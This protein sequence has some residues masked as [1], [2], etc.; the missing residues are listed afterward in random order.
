MSRVVVKDR[1]TKLYQFPLVSPITSLHIGLKSVQLLATASQDNVIRLWRLLNEREP[2]LE[3]DV[4]KGWEGYARAL[5]G[6]RAGGIH[7]GAGS[8]SSGGA[9]TSSIPGSSSSAP[10]S[11]FSII[12][13]SFD[14]SEELLLCGLDSGHILLFDL[15][16]KKLLRVF[17]TVGGLTSS[18]VT[19]TSSS[20]SSSLNPHSITCL[21][22]HPFGDYFASG[23]QDH[24]VKVWDM[25][26]KN[27]LQTYKGHVKGISALR[28]TPDG[29][30][31]VSGDSQG[32][33]KLWDLTAGKILTQF[34]SHKGAITCLDFHPTEFL[35][36]T[37]SEDGSVRYWDLDRFQLASGTQRDET[38]PLQ[39][40]SFTPDGRFLL[41][42]SQ[43]HLRV[44]SWEPDTLH[45]TVKI[46]WEGISDFAIHQGFKNGFGVAK[47][48]NELAAWC[49]ILEKLA[50]Y[51]E[52]YVSP[53][54]Q[55]KRSDSPPRKRGEERKSSGQ[56]KTSSSSRSSGGG[57]RQARAA[58]KTPVSDV[59]SSSQHDTESSS[60]SD[61]NLVPKN[62]TQDTQ[63][64]LNQLRSSQFNMRSEL[65]R[66]RRRQELE[67]KFR[68][69]RMGL[70]NG[71]DDESR[72]DKS[73]D[74]TDTKVKSSADSSLS[75]S[76]SV[77]TPPP[78]G[79]SGPGNTTSH[80]QTVSPTESQ[81]PVRHN[82]QSKE[83]ASSSQKKDDAPPPLQRKPFSQR[84]PQ[85]LHTDDN[86]NVNYVVNSSSDATPPKSRERS[87]SDPNIVV[88]LAADNNAH[89]SNRDDVYHHHKKAQ[90]SKPRR[91]AAEHGNR[92]TSLNDLE[93]QITEESKLMRHIISGRLASMN[94]VARLWHENFKLEAINHLC[95]L[96]DPAVTVDV[97]A[98]LNQEPHA[99]YFTLQMC[100]KLLTLQVPLMDSKYEPYLK[101][102]MNTTEQL[103]KRFYGMVKQSL[104]APRL[105]RN[106]A[107]PP[108][109]SRFHR[110]AKC[111]QL[112]LTLRG[113]L[114]RLRTRHDPL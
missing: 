32:D 86:G 79:E 17:C 47:R 70:D 10:T 99:N 15:T 75:A 27:C 49:V 50:P 52:G 96:D 9:S 33:V 22:F 12:C 105:G 8:G 2:L 71:S 16:K 39:C 5:T 1:T 108:A 73:G 113:Q 40:V 18:S 7:S 110:C 93:R 20:S 91:S 90:D 106:Q 58:T 84:K 38:E 92:P 4:G 3:M 77:T 82:Q 48:G 24:S 30:W 28:F 29:R 43:H 67:E 72:T 60:D 46:D 57:R 42:I 107:V 35:L 111:R 53:P 21:D 64:L 59:A 100:K 63:K 103:H 94:L 19:T 85:P 61:T 102:A 98:Q 89:S 88:P 23:S 87:H 69:R 41:A 112:F 80:P 34:C 81:S 65:R 104:H 55:E 51:K 68:R 74:N 109:D 56:P 62:T 76:P 54:P 25:K 83:S 11:Q 101:S 78:P 66:A 36:A 44:W 14:S 114:E 13:M 95:T 45:D 97:M 26:R 37:G 31:L 6:K